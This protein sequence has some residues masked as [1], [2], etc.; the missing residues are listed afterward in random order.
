MSRSRPASCP[1]ILDALEVERE[2]PRLVLEVQQHLGN[3]V[4]RCIAMETTDGLRRGEAV[5]ATGSP[6]MVPVGKR[7]LGRMFNVVGEPIDGGPKM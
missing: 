7:V 3:D 6:I 5:V 1:H 2:G 4:A